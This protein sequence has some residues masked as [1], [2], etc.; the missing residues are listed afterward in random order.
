MGKL[1][2]GRIFAGSIEGR[3]GA[4]TFSEIYSLKW[5]QEGR[6][7]SVLGERRNWKG[8]NIVN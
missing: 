8:K 1:S 3:R 7:I 5:I 6:R 2:K 4:L